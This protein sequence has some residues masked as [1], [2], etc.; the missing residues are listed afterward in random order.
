MPGGEGV[1]DAERVLKVRPGGVDGSSGHGG[2]VR[3]TG[4]DEG[5]DRLSCGGDG[6]GV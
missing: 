1:T 5:C 3:G 6:G 4:A 2:R